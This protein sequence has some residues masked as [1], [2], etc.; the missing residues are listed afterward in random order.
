MSSRTKY[1]L[2]VSCLGLVVIT[3]ER[4]AAVAYGFAAVLVIFAAPF[5]F[6]STRNKILQFLIVV[7]S[8]LACGLLIYRGLWPLIALMLFSSSILFAINYY[9]KTRGNAD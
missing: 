1:A 5:F 7:V 4:G 8:A 3:I 2:I 9:S 6:V